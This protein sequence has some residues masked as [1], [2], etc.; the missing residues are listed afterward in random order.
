[1]VKKGDWLVDDDTLPSAFSVYSP[2]Q[3]QIGRAVSDEYELLGEFLIDICLYRWDGKKV[4]RNSP[5]EGGP[6]T[7]E[8]AC[9]V[10]HWRQIKEPVF[11]IGDLEDLVFTQRKR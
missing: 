2:K 5:S 7:Y 1:M 11:P 9:D 6:Q 4:G 8:P 10:R 3:F